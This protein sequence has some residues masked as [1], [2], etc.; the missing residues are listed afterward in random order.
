MISMWYSLIIDPRL[1]SY[2][3]LKEPAQTLGLATVD[4]CSHALL[5]CLHKQSGGLTISTWYGIIPARTPEHVLDVQIKYRGEESSVLISGVF[6]LKGQHNLWLAPWS[7]HLRRPIQAVN[8]V[9]HIATC[10]LQVS[11]CTCIPSIKGQF[12]WKLLAETS[13]LQLTSCVHHSPMVS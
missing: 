3:C 5:W 13:M 9:G 1:V 6:F 2:R 8:S 12:Y 7:L 4:K 11:Q 10:Q